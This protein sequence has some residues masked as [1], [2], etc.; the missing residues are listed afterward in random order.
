MW[1]SVLNNNKNS[2]KLIEKLLVGLLGHVDSKARD[3]A[4]IHLNAFYDD[5]DWQI[6][7]P[8]K[9]KITSVSQEFCIREVLENIDP[10]NI[11]LEL[12]APGFYKSSKNYIVSYHTPEIRKT[13]EGYFLKV[14]LGKFIRCGFYD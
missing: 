6:S 5:T 13:S 10:N 3:L 8:L 1:F 11:I 14:F 12:H 7:Y 9:S 4:V 2:L